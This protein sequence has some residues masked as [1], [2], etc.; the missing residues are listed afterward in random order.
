MRAHTAGLVAAGVAAASLLVIPTVN[1]L[2]DEVAGRPGQAASSSA[3][4]AS[5]ASPTDASTTFPQRSKPGRGNAAAS[6]S[7]SATA[8]GT[9]SPRA[10]K[11][12]GRTGAASSSATSPAQGSTTPGGAGRQPGEPD[13]ET[14]RPGRNYSLPSLDV[15]VR[16]PAVT[17][18]PGSRGVTRSTSRSG[19]VSQEALTATARRSPEDVLG[20]YRLRLGRLGFSPMEVQLGA[21]T[22]GAG[23]RRG[24]DTVTV[25]ASRTDRTTTYSL[26]AT[27]RSPGTP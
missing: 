9:V 16:G 21:E 11:P 10:S 5:Q 22:E 13:I 20:W 8:G 7:A 19:R 6:S 26:L 3:G 2:A 17:P 14:G 25:V 27:L 18:L 4:S 1:G 15:E 12:G 24:G 23:F